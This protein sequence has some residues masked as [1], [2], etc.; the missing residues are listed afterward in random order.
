MDIKDA[1]FLSQIPMA[2][3]RGRV[4]GSCPKLWLPRKPQNPQRRLG[5]LQAG[6]AC[7]FC[8]SECPGVLG[9]YD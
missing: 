6:E 9:R 3:G 5:D 2:V 4:E 8:L 7:T 1:S